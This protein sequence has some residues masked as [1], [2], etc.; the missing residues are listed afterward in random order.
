MASVIFINT[1]VTYYLLARVPALSC[2]LG[3]VPCDRAFGALAGGCA[4]YDCA[5]GAL[6]VCSLSTAKKFDYRK[7]GFHGNGTC[8]LL[9]MSRMHNQHSTLDFH[10]AVLRNVVYI[11]NCV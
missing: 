6:I 7:I 3:H 2:R 11:I 5:F 4:L 9:V 1:C 10:H 8:T